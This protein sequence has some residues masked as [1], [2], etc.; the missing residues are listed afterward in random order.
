[1]DRLTSSALC[2]ILMLAGAA[3][4]RAEIVSFTGHTEA[5]V[6]EYR[7]GVAG[8]T[9]V[10]TESF[11]DTDPNLPLQV[12]ATLHPVQDFAPAAAAAAAQFADPTELAQQN[13][14]EFAINLTLASRSEVIRYDATAITSERR[15][16]LFTPQEIAGTKQGDTVT[17]IGRLFLDGALAVFAASSD[18]NLTGAEVVFN[19][20]VRRIAAE[21]QETVF[22]GSVTLRG[23]TGGDVNLSSEGSFPT[24]GLIFTNLAAVLP[25]FGAAGVLIIPRI[26]NE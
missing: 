5:R 12:V 25:D 20:T 16:V 13:P 14:E 24:G 15:T 7:E 1:M 26:T 3:A 8:D 11:P 18:A 10:A 19:V 2:G 4:A 9:D 17:Q 22:S 23:S 21:Q 6:Q